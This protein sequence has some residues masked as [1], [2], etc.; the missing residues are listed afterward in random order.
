L[1]DS[2]KLFIGAGKM[3][4]PLHSTSIGH[5]F[6]ASRVREPSILGM[7]IVE[8][9]FSLLD[10]LSAGGGVWVNSW[11]SSLDNEMSLKSYITRS[12]KVS[13]HSYLI[14]LTKW[15]S[16]SHL[17]SSLMPASNLWLSRRVYAYS[18]TSLPCKNLNNEIIISANS[19][20]K[21]SIY[22]LSIMSK[23]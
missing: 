23:K 19:S 20:V 4:S 18:K 12:V 17:R 1:K 15:F 3:Y 16:L 2:D 9:T 21:S 7:G 11:F 10:F 13:P 14:K 8:L 6:W 5:F 22:C